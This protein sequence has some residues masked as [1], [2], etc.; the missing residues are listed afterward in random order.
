MLGSSPRSS[1]RGACP[2]GRRPSPRRSSPTCARCRWPR[3]AT[4]PWVGRR[5]RAC[6]WPSSTAASTPTTRRRAGGRRGGAGLRP[7]RPGPGPGRRRAPRGPVRPRHRLRRDHPLA[8]PRGRA[9]QR[10]GARGQADRQG[11]G[12]RGRVCAGPS[13][14]GM[15]VVNLSLQHRASATT[16][17]SSTSWWTRPTSRLLLVCAVNNV[18]R[19]DLPVAV[20]LGALGRGQ[21][22][23]DPSASPT[24]R[25]RRWSSAPPASTSRCPGWAADRWATGN[26]FAAPHI[27]GLVARSARQHPELT[28]FQVKT[29]LQAVSDNVRPP[30]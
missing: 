1:G 4:G 6:G 10:A 14:N 24:T 23:D 12:V 25:P 13:T 2:P 30:S 19:P 21:R 17:P 18:A 29:V 5:A 15:Q 9:V 16:S 7:G 26:S 22:G 8:R 20:R 28:P 3:R 27:A 11:D